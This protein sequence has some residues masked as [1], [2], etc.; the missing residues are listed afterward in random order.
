MG[1]VHE[2]K[3]RGWKKNILAIFGDDVG[4]TNIIAYAHGVVGYK[5]PNIDRIAREGVMS[6]PSRKFEV[7]FRLYGLEKPLF[8]KT[9]KLPDIE[10]LN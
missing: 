7:T 10:K 3:G 5:T 4:Q 2:A 8:E 6:D 9:W 1:L